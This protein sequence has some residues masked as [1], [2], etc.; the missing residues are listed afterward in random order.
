MR[1]IFEKFFLFAGDLEPEF[2]STTI[3]NVDQTSLHLTSNLNLPDTTVDVTVRTKSGPVQT[4]FREIDDQLKFD[5][6]ISNLAPGTTY[7]LVLEPKYGETNG[8]PLEV[9]VTTKLSDLQFDIPE[10]LG[11]SNSPTTPALSSDPISDE[12]RVTWLKATFSVTGQFD[13][14]TVSIEPNFQAV[15]RE[16]VAN[17]T[18]VLLTELI[19]GE[20]YKITAIVKAG[21]W[22]VR[23]VKTVQMSPAR[24]VCIL[25][26]END[27][28]SVKISL[29]NNGKGSSFTYQLL[30]GNVILQSEVEHFEKYK[31]LTVPSNFFG[32]SFKAFVSLNGA[33]SQHYFVQLQEIELTAVTVS[34]LN[35][36]AELQVAFSANYANF[37]EI[38]VTLDPDPDPGVRVVPAPETLIG[39]IR[40]NQVYCGRDIDV[41]ITPYSGHAS[42]GPAYVTS[43]SFPPCVDFDR[44][45]EKFSVLLDEQMIQIS[46]SVPFVGDMPT[47]RLELTDPNSNLPDVNLISKYIRREA[48]F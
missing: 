26:Q 35:Q 19:P 1:K 44:I 15:F 20:T 5:M 28:N 32:K 13:N 12:Y 34:V 38:K 30:D 3:D 2:K 29:L 37:G 45:E 48:F 18:E 40:V 6:A 4:Q 23:E 41:E 22:S 17:P 14:I 36:T 33:E 7:T 8:D 25:F 9:T 21:P 47:F 24:P 39:S 42:L 46:I 31:R 16:F 10:T 11:Q 27:D 43:V